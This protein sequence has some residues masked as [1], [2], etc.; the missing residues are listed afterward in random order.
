MLDVIYG[1]ILLMHVNNVHQDGI[2]H[3]L[4]ASQLII[5][6]ENLIKM[7]HVHHAIQVMIWSMEFVYS[8]H[9]ILKDHQM[10]DVELGLMEFVHN[11]L[12]I[13]SLM[14]IMS[15]LKFKDYVELIQDWLVQVVMLV[16]I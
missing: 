8:H 9:Q 15:V 11:V 2:D 5:S 4:D 14:K 13:G 1:I 3:Q 6:V 10:L 7:E 12:S 16:M